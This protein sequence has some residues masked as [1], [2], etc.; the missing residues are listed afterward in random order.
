ME[1]L[2]AIDGRFILLW[3]FSPVR[4]HDPAPR[5]SNQGPIGLA[6]VSICII[7]TL[8]SRIQTC[9]EILSCVN[10]KNISISTSVKH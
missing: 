9:I 10:T 4:I 3:V 5:D 6:R 1:I 7:C 2:E 8:Q